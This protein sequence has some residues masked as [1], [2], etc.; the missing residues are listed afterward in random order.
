MSH[1]S[2]TK[3]QGGDRFSRNRPFSAHSRNLWAGWS[4]SPAQKLLARS[5]TGP[6]IFIKILSFHQKLF[7]FL[8]RT[9]RHTDTQ[10]HRHTDRQTDRQTH[11]PASIYGRA[12][13]FYACFWYL[14]TSL[15]S[16]RSLRSWR[17]NLWI[18][19]KNKAEVFDKYPLP[20]L[21][22]MVL[23]KL[24]SV[25]FLWNCLQRNF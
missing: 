11:E 23:F 22:Q 10:T 18:N 12:K 4:D 14:F 21:E 13:F 20:G 2:R 9:D 25:K 8:I 16:L 6:E 3:T 15:R 24:I 1:P 17:I 7:N 5:W 19:L